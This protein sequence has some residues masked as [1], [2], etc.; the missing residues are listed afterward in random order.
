MRVSDDLKDTYYERPFL[1]LG[2]PSMTENPND[3]KFYKE[4]LKFDKIEEDF[5]NLE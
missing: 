5:K 4:I 3:C 1:L 2:C